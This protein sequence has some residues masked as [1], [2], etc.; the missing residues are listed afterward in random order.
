MKTPLLASLL[1]LLGLTG[2]AARKPMTYLVLS[3]V[4]GPVYRVSGP[5]IAVGQVAMPP[6]I[7]RSF[8]TVGESKTT[9]AVSYNAQWA[10][11]LGGM[12]QT[13]LARDLAARLPDHVV[14]MPGDVMSGNVLV[15]A[16]NVFNFLP[17]PGQVVLDADWSIAHADSKTVMQAGRER[18]V[19]PSSTT[20]AGQAQA[21]SQAL[22]MLADQIAA[23]I[24]A[25]K[26]EF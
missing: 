22:G 2:C 7:D 8:L 17:Y 19:T 23:R 6:A 4:S 10:A 1:V 18:L 21:M 20:P 26:Q 15:I 3:P 11:P 9:L 14:L 13:I 16:V 5:P 25:A 12:A 24:A